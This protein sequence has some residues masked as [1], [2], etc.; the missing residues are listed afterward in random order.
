LGQGT[1]LNL[2][3]ELL[4]LEHQLQNGAARPGHYAALEISDAF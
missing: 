3:R 2:E 1:F 4:S